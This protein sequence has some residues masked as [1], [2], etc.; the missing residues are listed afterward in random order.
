MCWAMVIL[1]L[2][3][4]Q[5]AHG[6]CHRVPTEDIVTTVNVVPVDGESPTR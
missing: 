4:G 2:L 3:D 5:V 6:K 1:T